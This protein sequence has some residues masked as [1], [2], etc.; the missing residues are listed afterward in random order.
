MRIE[1]ISLALARRISLAAQGFGAK[2][3]DAPM[4]AHLLRVLGKTQLY[5][6][7]SVNV[8]S[9]AHYL[10]AFSRLGAYDRADLDEL[11]WGSKRK[12]KLFEYWAHEASMLP[13]DLHPLL[14]WRMTQADRGEAGWG[15][16]RV[17]ATDQRVEAMAILDRI[18]SEGPHAASDFEAPRPIGMVGMERYQARSRMAVLGRAHYHRDAARQFR[19]GLR[20]LR[21]RDPH[22]R[23]EPA[24]A[25]RCGG[26]S[27]SN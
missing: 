7:D 13:F 1:R 11:V 18:R 19:A 26:I 22:G 9:R 8:L 20:S 2:Q 17:Y 24:N 4:P 14:R 5:Q 6:I 12:R 27:R 23:I 15:R 3:P 10:P 16:M 21:T 25:D